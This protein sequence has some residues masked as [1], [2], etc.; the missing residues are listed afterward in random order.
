MKPFKSR[1][2]KTITLLA[3]GFILLFLFRFI[4]GY[5]TGLNEFQEEDFSNFFNDNE[6]VSFK[7]NYASDNYKFKRLELT[8]S[9]NAV[10]QPHEFDVNQKYEKTATVRSRSKEFEKDEKQVRATIKKFNAIIQYEQNAG[11]TGNRSIHFLIGTP[12][13]KFDSLYNEVL[14][15]GIV[16]SKEITKIDKTNEYKNLNAKKAS[17]EITRQSLLDI[18]KQNGKIDEYINL[19]N[20]ILEI[21]QELQSLGVL[22]GDFNEENEFCTVKFSLS[23][24]H[25]VKVSFLHRVKVAFEWTVQYYLLILCIGAAAA[26]FGFFFLLIIDKLLPSILSKLNS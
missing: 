23:E 13:E 4:Y 8:S 9:A 18:K 11:R 2:I 14:K 16:R 7:R 3:V 25:E 19:Q 5:T 22:L 1:L 6:N 20:R 15:I 17:L 24:T 12:P 21:E 10:T 26:V